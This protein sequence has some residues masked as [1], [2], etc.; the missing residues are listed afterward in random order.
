MSKVRCQI[1]ISVD[2]F[3][4]GPNQSLENPLGEGGM[5]LHEWAFATEGWRRHHGL[6]GGER[7]P[8]S[9]VLDDVTANVGA[10][11]MGRN[12]FG[13]GP[14]DWK[15]DWRGWWGEDPPF[16]VPVCVLT[17]H[18][19]EP[20]PMQGGTTFEFV[21]DGIEA[22]LARARASAGDKDVEIAGGAQAVRHSWPPGCWRS[23]TCTWRR[24]CSEVASGCSRTSA[25]PNS[26][27][28]TWSPRRRSPTSGIASG[29]S[30]GATTAP[31][32]ASTAATVPFAECERQMKAVYSELPEYRR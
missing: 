26:S 27:R 9:D 10:Y 19:H 30:A 5:R 4:A 8:D 3:V 24:S 31:V 15:P 6:D 1:S 28:S 20:L 25:I 29:A 21:T 14:G 18:A 7:T 22:A 12:M 32:S 2:G 23:C 13:G 16:H 11:I 17:H